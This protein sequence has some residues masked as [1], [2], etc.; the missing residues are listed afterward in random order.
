MKL[1]FVELFMLVASLSLSFILSEEFSKKRGRSPPMQFQATSPSKM[2][3]EKFMEIVSPESQVKS[4]QFQLRPRPRPL[5]FSYTSAFLISAIPL[6]I[7]KIKASFKSFSK[8]IPGGGLGLV[9]WLTYVSGIRTDITDI[10]SP[11]TNLTIKLTNTNNPT[12]SLTQSV[13]ASA[14]NTNS[15]NDSLTQANTVTVTNSN[16]GRKR[17]A[18]GKDFRKRRAITDY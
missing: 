11:N 16:S 4:R 13:T 6:V 10:G 12:I 18:V 8:I 5:G 7:G 14:V 9:Y 15:D 2:P 1:S 3:I 17:R